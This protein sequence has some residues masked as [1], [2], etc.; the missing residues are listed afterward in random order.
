MLVDRLIFASIGGPAVR[1]EENAPAH[2]T[3]A[4]PEIASKLPYSAAKLASQCPSFASLCLA[5]T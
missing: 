3:G 5:S 2:G 4:C 1:G